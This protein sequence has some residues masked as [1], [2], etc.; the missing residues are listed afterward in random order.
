MKIRAE[1]NEIENRKRIEKISETKSWF[2]VKTNKIDIDRLRK[3]IQITKIGNESG[4]IYYWFYR[5]KND[6]N[7]CE[8]SNAN[9]FDNVEELDKFLETKNLPR[10]NH[11]EIENLNRHITSKEIE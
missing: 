5:N 3:K 2:F 6:Y 9:K 11:Q 1:K 8:Q 7:Y 4:D 10:E